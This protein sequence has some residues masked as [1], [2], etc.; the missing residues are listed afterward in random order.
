MDV[1]TI[2]SGAFQ[3]MRG[4]IKDLKQTVTELAEENKKLKDNR[5]MDM[6][7]AMEHTGYGKTWFMA[8]KEDIGYHQVEGGPIKFYKEDLDKFFKAHKIQRKY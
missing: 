6:N 3:E 4:W 1:L 5:L 7:E 8:H 2:E